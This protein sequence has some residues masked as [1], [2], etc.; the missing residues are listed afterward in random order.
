MVGKI[1]IRI[2]EDKIMSTRKENIFRLYIVD[3][4]GSVNMLKKSSNVK[5]LYEKA[6]QVQLFIK[7]Y[8]LSA[9]EVMSLQFFNSNW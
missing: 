5:W 4:T 3:K 1:E 9:E 7:S 8:D 2:E 6:E